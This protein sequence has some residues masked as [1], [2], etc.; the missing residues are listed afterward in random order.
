M[1]LLFTPVI[2]TVFYFLYIQLCYHTPTKATTGCGYVHLRQCVGYRC[3]S[4]N[5]ILTRFNQTQTQSDSVKVVSK[6]LSKNLSGNTFRISSSL[7]LSYSFKFTAKL[8]APILFVLSITYLSLSLSRVSHHSRISIFALLRLG[9][10]WERNLNA[11]HS[12][13]MVQQNI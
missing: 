4:Q 1:F 9:N 8:V 13:R 12:Y 7:S 3:L 6:A 10:F 11:F 2:V 5:L